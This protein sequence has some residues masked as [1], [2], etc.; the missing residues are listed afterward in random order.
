MEIAVGVGGAVRGDEQV[1]ALE[2]GGVHR[3]Q[4]DLHRPLAQLGG[5]GGRGG[6]GSFL[7]GQLPG[8]APRAAAGQG[9]GLL[10][11]HQVLFHRGFV[12]GGGFPLHKRD[13]SRGAGGEAVPQAVAV[14]FPEE[15][16]LALYHGDGPLVAGGGAGAAAVAFLLVDVDDLPD[17][18]VVA[19][20]CG[21]P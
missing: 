10:S 5:N 8:V 6:L 9:S 11:L 14:V 19:P 16:G 18:G 4:F 15:R 17:H 2:V 13:G 21:C 20:F 1:G 3:G 12:V 7:P